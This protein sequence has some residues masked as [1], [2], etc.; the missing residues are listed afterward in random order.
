MRP[1]VAG[2]WKMNG[3]GAD[4]AELAAL[5]AALSGRPAG[6]D[7]LVCPPATLIAKAAGQAGGAFAI[8]AQDCHPRASGAFT[9]DISA[10]MLKDAGASAVIVGHSER[11]Q[12]HGETDS[13]VAAKAA[14]AWR[15]GLLAIVCIG[16]TSAQRDAGT[17][18]HICGSQLDASLPDDA[19]AGN[20]AIAYEPVWAIGTGRTPSDGD[21]AAMHAHIRA[22]LVR[23]FGEEAR[24]IRILYGGSVKPSNAAQILNLPEVG[25]ALVGG[26]SLKAADFEAI[27]RGVKVQD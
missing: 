21:I 1:L 9:G 2:N 25:G 22:C 5:K 24:G 20:T 15:A 10:E 17:A 4:L 13:D 23:R 3:L 18:N 11:R 7:V 12:F 8:G 26:A 6:C 27:I 19:M 14:A 16:E